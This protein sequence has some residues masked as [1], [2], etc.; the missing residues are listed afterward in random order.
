MGAVFEYFIFLIIQNLV[1]YGTLSSIKYFFL[2]PILNCESKIE[3]SAFYCENQETITFCNTI[4]Q[5]NISFS[6]FSILFVPIS[7][8]I[9]FTNIILQTFQN[10]WHNSAILRKFIV[11]L[12]SR[13]AK[14]S[15]LLKLSIFLIENHG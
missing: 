7:T 4:A 8:V 6:I 5:R 15:K 12:G 13:F 10:L 3:N 11:A 2:S 9:L 1:S 14:I